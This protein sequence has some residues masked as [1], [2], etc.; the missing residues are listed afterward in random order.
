ME[1]KRKVLSTEEKVK[2]NCETEN[3]RK[4]AD[5]CREFGLVNSTVQSQ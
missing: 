2:V 3:G 4:K 5:V 1:M